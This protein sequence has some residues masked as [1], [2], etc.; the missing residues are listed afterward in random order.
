MGSKKLNNRVLSSYLDMC[1][2]IIESLSSSL[3]LCSAVVVACHLIVSNFSC[4]YL[5]FVSDQF[6]NLSWLFNESISFKKRKEKNTETCC[7]HFRAIY[8]HGSHGDVLPTSFWQYHPTWQTWFT[9]PIFWNIIENNRHAITENGEIKMTIFV[10]YLSI[11]KHIIKE[12]RHDTNQKN[13][14]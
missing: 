7:S 6:K 2:L 1:F 9:N 10:P 4:K 14:P 3:V 11:E 13:E 5:S 8:C 12:L